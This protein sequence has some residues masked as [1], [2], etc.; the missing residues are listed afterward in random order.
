[1]KTLQLI[2][3]V[4]T[5][6]LALTSGAALATTYYF[7][8]AS[9]DKAW[10]NGTNR[11][12][13]SCSGASANAVPTAN[14]D[15]VICE[16]KVAEVTDTSAVA[17]TITVQSSHG[18]RIDIKPSSGSA[19]TLTLGS[20]S[21][22]LTSALGDGTAILLLDVE[23]S[24]NKATLAIVSAD[25]TLQSGQIAGSDD[26]AKITI[27]S[28]KTL[29][30]ETGRIHGYLKIVRAGKFVSKGTIV[31]ADILG[32]TVLIV[33][34]ELDDLVAADGTEPVWRIYPEGTLQFSSDISVVTGG[35]LV[36]NFFSGGGSITTA[37]IVVD[38]ALT[39][40]GSLTLSGCRLVVN[41]NLTMGSTNHPCSAADCSIE[42]VANKTFI[43]Y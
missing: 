12:T 2:I 26:L 20:G 13:V 41:Q 17:R 21:N 24:T 30:Y 22:P 6:V 25:H 10:N 8:D 36:G 23:S 19:A 32:K 3:T 27:A 28:G 43:H 38:E 14:D 35:S 5:I 18:A 7:T 9:A 34:Y 16:G 31:Q 29:T 11:S 42:V 15:G 37:S 40:T 33:P 4:T 1:M 39:T